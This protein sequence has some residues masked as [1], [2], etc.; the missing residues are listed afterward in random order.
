MLRCAE[1]RVID[2]CVLHGRGLLHRFTVVGL[3]LREV[4]WSERTMM[5]RCGSFHV[6]MAKATLLLCP[7]LS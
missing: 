6:K 5:M 2:G 7:P 1:M 3:W 4:V